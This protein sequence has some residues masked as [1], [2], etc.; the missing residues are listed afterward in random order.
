LIKSWQVMS[1]P[2][3]SDSRPVH[4]VP[5]AIRSPNCSGWGWSFPVDRVS[6]APH[7]RHRAL[8]LAGKFADGH[9]QA[10]SHGQSPSVGSGQACNGA[11]YD[12]NSSSGALNHVDE[13]WISW[14][15]RRRLKSMTFLRTSVRT[16]PSERTKPTFIEK[17]RLSGISRSR[18]YSYAPSWWSYASNSQFV[19]ESGESVDLV[20]ARI[21]AP[22]W[23]LRAEPSLSRGSSSNAPYRNGTDHCN[24]ANN[25]LM[26]PEASPDRTGHAIGRSDRTCGRNARRS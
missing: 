1:I 7:K 8:D 16:E 18:I 9:C 13:V 12:L 4:V 14:R 25:K 3:G 2:V 11:I 22:P 5:Q 6:F 21:I 23:R 26:R 24:Q 10:R 15:T 19:A 17:T 20:E